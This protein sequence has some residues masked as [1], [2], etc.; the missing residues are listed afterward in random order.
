MENLRNKYLRCRP[1][2]IAHDIDEARMTGDLTRYVDLAK[3]L[4]VSDAVIV[5]KESW[6]L[7]QRVTLKCAVPRCRNY[8]TCANCPPY[9]TS[10][11]ETADLIDKYNKGIL[12]R[13]VYHREAAYDAGT[14]SRRGLYPALA[15]IEAAAFYDGYYF[16][17]G[18]GAGSCR[19]GLCGDG[20][21]QE[22]TEPHKGCRHPLL[23]RPSMEAVGFDVYRTAARAG[24]IMNPAG[25]HCPE[26]IGMFSRIAIVLIT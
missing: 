10:A 6:Y 21:C 13:W 22:L 5:E 26:A 14:E 16:A 11:S 25:S 19:R 1:A 17:C 24:W 18:F 4:G 8:S 2:S 7:D 20:L 23:A 12:L 15:A 3:E 9:T